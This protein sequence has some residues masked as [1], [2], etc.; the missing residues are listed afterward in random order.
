V[1]V[2][3]DDVRDVHVQVIDHDAEVVGRHA[4]GAQQDEIVE[5]GVGKRDRAFD[6][7]VPASLALLRRAKADD[8]GL[9][10]GRGL[11]FRALGTPAAVIARFFTAGTLL[12]P[13]SLQFLLGR[14]TAVRMPGTN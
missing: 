4:V 2:A 7:I 10:L 9:I 6:E 3:A 11:A 13:E 1:I 5:L 14:P 8:R 12:R